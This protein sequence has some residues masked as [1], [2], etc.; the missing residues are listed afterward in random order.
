[1]KLVCLGFFFS[2]KQE[3]QIV[4]VC[5]SFI[6]LVPFY[7]LE[8]VHNTCTYLNKIILAFLGV[9]ALFTQQS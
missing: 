3:I 5:H 1:M 6:F 7:D 9:M 4:S 8:G 2:N